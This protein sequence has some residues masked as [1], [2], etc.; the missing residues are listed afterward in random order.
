MAGHRFDA[1]TEVA[2]A[3]AAVNVAAGGEGRWRHAS[4]ACRST[5]TTPE[6]AE[7]DGAAADGGGLTP[8]PGEGVPLLIGGGALDSSSG[9]R[10]DSDC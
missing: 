5:T 10:P 6:K 8:E 4:A 9:L 1:A 2:A 3:V 7:T